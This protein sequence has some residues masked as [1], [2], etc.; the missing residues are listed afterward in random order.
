MADPRAIAVMLPAG[1]DAASGEKRRSLYRSVD[2][3]GRG[4]VSLADVDQ[5]INGLTRASLF[6]TKPVVQCAF[7]AAKDASKSE[8]PGP[9][10][11][12]EA[13]FRHAP[14]CHLKCMARSL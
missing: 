1:R 7:E 9:H 10:F 2:T 13:E 3:S 5:C 4:C 14:P 11:L 6:A 8:Q 12:S